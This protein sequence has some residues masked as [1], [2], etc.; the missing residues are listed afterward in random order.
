[1][2]V[3]PLIRHLR[4]HGEIDNDDY[5]DFMGMMRVWYPEVQK[6]AYEGLLQQYFEKFWELCKLF[7]SVYS[8]ET[9]TII[10]KKPYLGAYDLDDYVYNRG[11]RSLLIRLGYKDTPVFDF[12]QEI[13][14]QRIHIQ[15]QFKIIAGCS[16]KINK[17]PLNNILVDIFEE[18]APDDE[19][20]DDLSSIS[21]D[22]SS[23][24]DTEE[25]DRIAESTIEA[26]RS[27]FHGPNPYRN[28]FNMAQRPA[29]WFHS[30]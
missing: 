23:S 30:S 4:E 27:E 28:F 12:F 19:D 20:K 14:R 5:T 26:V 18:F 9:I 6:S 2:S 13:Q 16:P 3:H 25:V 1:M 21:T 22:S 8:K 17:F 15:K 29:Y 7:P 11:M 10:F 24:I